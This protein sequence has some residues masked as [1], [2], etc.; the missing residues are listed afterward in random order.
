MPNVDSEFK[1]P[2]DLCTTRIYAGVYDFAVIFRN[3]VNNVG[4]WSCRSIIDQG[5]HRMFNGRKVLKES[6][7]LV[8][9][10]TSQVCLA[11]ST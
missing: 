3:E 11:D 6:R 7:S 2:L 4:R 1:Q 5:S 8:G 9:L 10:T